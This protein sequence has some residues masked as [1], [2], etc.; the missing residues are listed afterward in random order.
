MVIL[1]LGELL[2]RLRHAPESLQSRLFPSEPSMW[3]CHYGYL[4]V[5]LLSSTFPVPSTAW[6]FH[7]IHLH[8]LIKFQTNRLNTF[9]FLIH[10]DFGGSS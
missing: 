8:L 10:E 9:S 4:T 2:T 5:T 6:G 7:L 3:V 1:Y